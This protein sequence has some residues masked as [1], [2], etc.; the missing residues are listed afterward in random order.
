[1]N[2]KNQASNEAAGSAHIDPEEVARFAAIASEW[3]DANGKFRPL[4]LLAP[5]RIRFIRDQVAAHFSRDPLGTQP[6]RELSALDIGCGGGLVS[7]P[8]ARL[9][10]QMTGIDPAGAS[11]DAARS[12]ARGQALE[13][14]YR[15]AW[16]EDLVAEGAQFDIVL[17]LEV[18]EH[19]PDVGAFINTCRAL[20]APGG[21]MVLS[22]INRTMKS[23]AMAIIGAE[24]ILRWLPTGTHTWSRFVTP[25][26]MR[27]HVAAAGL[28]VGDVQGVVMDPLSGNWSLS[29]TDVDVNY[30][31]VAFE[32]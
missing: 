2:D 29:D 24:Y 13:I 11:L 15:D 7:E 21:I 30:M 32:P 3:W 26:E 31:A 14:L 22:T 27:K 8:L 6:L 25:D 10:A 4:H 19:V 12:H 20:V 18:V 28:T 23:Y 16:A 5:T 9:G 1:M 17:C